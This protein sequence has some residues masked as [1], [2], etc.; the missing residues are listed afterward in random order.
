M[1]NLIARRPTEAT[2]GVALFVATYAA[3]VDA[4]AP[5]G[6]AIA[7]AFVVGFLPAVVTSIVDAVRRRPPR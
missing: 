2:S 5:N 3:L 4:G 1:K 6:V 7:L